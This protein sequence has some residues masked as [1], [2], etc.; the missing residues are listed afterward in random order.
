MLVSILRAAVIGALAV[1][2][3]F[4]APGRAAAAASEP[5]GPLRLKI[6]TDGRAN[7]QG[8]IAIRLRNESE[9]DLRDVVLSLSIAQKNGVSVESKVEVRY[10]PAR[11]SV[12]TTLWIPGAQA[13]TVGEMKVEKA[14]ARATKGQARPRVEV[15]L[16]RG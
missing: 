3:T 16:E 2:P 14:R 1:I 9:K 15:E 12:P 13:S 8:T 6:E 7:A 5:N 10:L 4:V 11:S